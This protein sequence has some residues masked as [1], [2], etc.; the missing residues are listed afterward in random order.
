MPGRWRPARYEQ[1]GQP[2]FQSAGSCDGPDKFKVFE[3]D[4]VVS[5]GGKQRVTPDRQRPWKVVGEG[6]VD[7][8]TG[9]IP[10]SVPRQGAEKVLRPHHVGVI[11]GRDDGSE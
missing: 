6:T 1:C 7:Q 9:G 2:L 5:A 10:A 4:P 8:R 3:K 11:Q